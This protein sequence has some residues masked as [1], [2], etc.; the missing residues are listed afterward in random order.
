MLRAKTTA[1]LGQDN[2]IELYP[3]TT[4]MKGETVAC[5]RIRAPAQRE[6][7]K[8]KAESPPTDSEMD[9]EIPF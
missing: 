6:L 9:K 7:P 1:T 3:T 4:E 8:P 5:I 2:Q